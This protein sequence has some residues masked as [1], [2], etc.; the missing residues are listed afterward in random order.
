MTSSR[1]RQ[2]SALAVLGLLC[3]ALATAASELSRLG[4]ES[5]MEYTVVGASKYAQRPAAAAAAVSVITRD[6]IRAFGW[7]T[8]GEALASLPGTHLGNDRQFTG[9]GARGFSIASDFNARLL[10]TING[11]RA[12]SLVY[13]SL[14][15]DRSIPLDLALIERIEFIPGPGGAVYGQNALFG[16]VNIVTRT[17]ASF[18]GGEVALAYQDPQRGRYGRM[19][20]GKQLDN[21]VDVLFSAT[22]Y[23]ADGEDRYYTYPGADLAYPGFA[24]SAGVAR[25]KDAEHDREFLARLAGG[26]WSFDFSYGDRRKDDPTAIYYSVPLRGKQYQS[27]EYNLAQLQFQDSFAADTLHFTG[28]VFAGRVRYGNLVQYYV[29][30]V[31]T[32]DSDWQGVELRLLSTAIAGHKLMVGL[33]YQ[34]N[35]RIDQYS[36][37]LGPPNLRIDIPGSGWRAGVYVQDEWSLNDRLTATVGLRV[38]DNNVVRA[39]LSPRLGLIWNA[40]TT[41]T[42]KALYGRAHRAPNAYER[43]YDNHGYT[44]TGNPGL[45]GE[46]IDTVELVLDHQLTPDASVRASIYRWKLKDLIVQEV[47]PES[48]LLQFRSGS[49]VTA[50]GIELSGSQTWRWGGHLRGSLTYQ[51]AVSESGFPRNSAP[52]WLGKLNFSTPLFDSGVQMGAELQ[53]TGRRHGPAGYDMGGY[54]LSNLHFSKLMWT[55]GLTLSAGIYNLFN[56]RYE[57]PLA[58]SWSPAVEQDGRSVRLMATYSF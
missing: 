15:V 32:G 13:D 28:R 33:E 53:Y 52:K 49:D 7:R 22:D 44:H 8:V 4:L 10:I 38:D 19:T 17:G 54:W 50:D 31:T 14:T 40:S 9:L 58:V 51:D 27:I 57:H 5:L 39:E 47:N 36:E 35:S 45:K 2:A 12:N 34:N 23:R 1:Y 43:D 18:D 55:K 6:E 11:N 30:V 48:G 20:W 37:E 25:G 41:T 46:T 56:E 3:P 26:R 29:P 16:V 42:V 24:R 21:G